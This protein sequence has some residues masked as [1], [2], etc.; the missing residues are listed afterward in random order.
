MTRVWFNHWFSTAYRLIELMKENDNDQIYV[1]ATNRQIDAV[2]QK[3]CDEWYQESPAVG[4][5]YIQY[6]LDFCREH[7]IDAFIPRRNMVEVSR[8][9]ERFNA[10]GV[11]VMVDD[12]EM[13]SVI[14]NNIN[15]V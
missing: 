8:N 4:E 12:Y 11:K 1:I 2:I 7:K 6:C 15:N 9:I 5:E 3:V 13:I 10:I 14:A